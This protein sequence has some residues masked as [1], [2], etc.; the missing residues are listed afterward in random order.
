L[1]GVI[2]AAGKGTRLKELGR[3]IPKA[4]LP[5]GKKTCLEHIILGM[6]EAGIRRFG[7]VIGHLGE[8]IEERYGSGESLGVEINYLKQDL[9]VYGTG[10]AV[11]L[12]KELAG[13][14]PLMVSYGDIIIEPSNYQA[15][16]ELA[17]LEQT[18]VSSVNWMD[19]PSA[20]AAVYFNEEG[21]L[22]DIIEKPPK[23]SSTT[24]WNNAGVYVFQPIIFDYL[25]QLGASKRGE[26]ELS[27]AL[28]MMVQAKVPVKAH[29]ITGYWKDIG[30]PEDVI[31]IRHLLGDK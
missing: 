18:C 27:G 30:T 20:G 4:L 17:R 25:A 31:A 29:K 26:Y 9:S 3:D 22:E 7:I 16:L 23:G 19:D 13:D 28:R 6:K 11:L 21:F 12:A 2:L 14:S 5:I 15:M 24:N 8:M 1:L 10:R